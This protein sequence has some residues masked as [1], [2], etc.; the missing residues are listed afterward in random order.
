VD[1]LKSSVAAS[2]PIFTHTDS[3]K[4]SSSVQRVIVVGG[5][6]KFNPEKDLHSDLD[7]LQLK[8]VEKKPQQCFLTP[9]GRVWIL[10][11]YITEMPET[12]S[13]NEKLK[14]SEYARFRDVVGGWW[15]SQK[16][17]AEHWH[18]EFRDLDDTETLGALVGLGLA[19]YNFLKCF[20][21][22]AKSPHWS[23]ETS[24]GPVK[25]ELIER[26]EDLVSGMNFARH[27]ANLPPEIA[28]P[29]EIADA[30]PKFFKGRAHLKV[31]VWDVARLKKEKMGL[32]LGVGQGSQYGAR[33]VHLKYRGGGA[34]KSV[35]F[36]GKGVTFDTGGLD[37]KNAS[38]MRWMK[39]DMSGAAI[40]AGLAHFVSSAKLKV[41]CDF[42]LPLAENSVSDRAMRPGDVH[43]S[44]AGHLVEIDNTDAEG[45]LVMADAIDVA[46]KQTGKDAPEALIDVSTL[47]GAMRVAVGLDVA[48]FFSNNDKLAREFET[49]A[50]SMG[51]MAWRMPLVE[52]YWRQMSSTFADF[53]NSSESGFAG[54]IT[55]ALF[56]KQFVGQTPWVHFDMMAW[57][58]SGDGAIG[59]GSNAQCFQ[60]LAGYLLER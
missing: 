27:L 39:K 53:K 14:I 60:I 49:A 3:A 24:K 36:V 13:H 37:L 22:E 23:F 55:A 38:G 31:D 48:G 4:K 28:N 12:H 43:Q 52:K 57:N 51:E 34:Q 26:A 46:V 58:G 9:S 8:S 15:R 54:A 29:A 45:R 56:L 6:R 2:L 25:K 41:N 33:F 7:E 5:K 50:Q 32:L 59:E 30:L 10:Q 16:A 47:T 42:Y 17:G 1:L 11:P 44:R 40:L 35:A 20:K 21:G 18:F 19:Q